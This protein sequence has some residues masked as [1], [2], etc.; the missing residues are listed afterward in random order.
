MDIR[1]F[2]KDIFKWR[3]EEP[4]EAARLIRFSLFLISLFLLV[5]TVT[6]IFLLR[7]TREVQLPNVEGKSLLEAARLL[8]KNKLK[9]HLI[10]KVSRIHPRY[11]IISQ[12]PDPGMIVKQ[13]RTIFLTVSEGEKI[14]RMPNFI[15]SNFYEA[16]VVL[17]DLFSA[18]EK[19]P[20]IIEERRHSTDMEKDYIIG[21]LPRPGNPL[22]LDESIVFQVSR[23]LITNAI[24]IISYRWM[25][26][27]DVAR[28]LREVG[29]DVK[30]R[31]AVSLDPTKVGKVFHQSVP[32]GAMLRKGENILL[33]VG[34]GSDAGKR[35]SRRPVY[36]VYTFKVPYRT[37]ISGEQRLPPRSNQFPIPLSSEERKNLSPG[38]IRKIDQNLR[39]LK[40]IVHDQWGKEIRFHEKVFAGSHIDIPYKTYGRGHLEVYVD[41]KY[42]GSWKF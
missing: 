17:R 31:T 2:L 42:Y 7:S 26:Y 40:I 8:Q 36:R 6:F 32:P 27:K 24:K 14:S 30:V 23:G 39:D 21:H 15:S 9:I 4:V 11:E 25:N 13:N 18:Y 16:K 35:D 41:K 20:T 22:N 33:T 34:V 19:I 3:D 5:F 1:K 28:K 29:I 38:Q 12:N 37:G 10:S